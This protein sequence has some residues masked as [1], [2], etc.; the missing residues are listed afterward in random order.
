MNTLQEKHAHA[1]AYLEYRDKRV[2]NTDCVWR[3]TPVA[4]TDVRKTMRAAQR[5]IVTVERRIC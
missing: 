3:P 2:A 4:K 1:V 5:E